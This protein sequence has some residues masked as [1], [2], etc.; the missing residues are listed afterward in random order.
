MKHNQPIRE[1]CRAVRDLHKEGNPFSRESDPDGRPAECDYDW[2]V[3]EK[4]QTMRAEEN[5]AIEWVN[6]R[7]AKIPGWHNRRLVRNYTGAVWND[8]Y[9]VVFCRDI[10]TGLAVEGY[11]S[12]DVDSF[13][14]WILR[15]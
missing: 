14:K 1:W 11:E 4:W 15:R 2:K 6:E 8:H 13:V 12:V 3:A 7:L 5:G 9:G 10:K